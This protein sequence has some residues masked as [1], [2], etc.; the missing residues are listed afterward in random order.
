MNF[1][2]HVPCEPLRHFISMMWFGD[3]YVVP[4]RLERVLPTGEMCLIINL[5]EDRTRVY[6][7]DDPRKLTTC[8][9]SIVVGAYSAFTVIDTDEQRAT[10]GVIFRPGGAF[11]FLDLPATE[12]QDRGAPLS[13]LWGRQATSELREQLLAARSPEAKF[14]ILEHTFLKRI[15]APLEPTHPAVSFAV[16]NFR[17]RPT[18]PVSSVTDQIGLSDRR[19]IQLFSHQVGLTPK[20]FCRV[21]RFQKVLRNITRTAAGSAIDWPQI[22]LTCGYFDQAHFIHDF[23]AFSGI[24]PTTYVA[25][26][27]QFQNHVV[28]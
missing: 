7:S 24:N 11:P 18:R 26:K 9:G 22:A 14:K 2:H 28:I 23:R 6:N 15:N 5:W 20:L 1:H 8:E 13:D 3:D 27:T 19:F 10:A 25:N 4:Y 12:L 17:Q 16:E 21:Q